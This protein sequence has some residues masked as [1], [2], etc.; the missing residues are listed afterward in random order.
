MIAQKYLAGF[1]VI[2]KNPA[3]KIYLPSN[4]NG[5]LSVGSDS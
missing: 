5:I 2:S 1:E 4:F 3:E